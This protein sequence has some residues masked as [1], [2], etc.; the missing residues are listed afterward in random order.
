MYILSSLSYM[1]SQ[2]PSS[3]NISIS[4]FVDKINTEGLINHQAMLM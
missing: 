1:K 4:N 3:A 2:N